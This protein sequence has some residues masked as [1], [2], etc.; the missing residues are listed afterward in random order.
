M[1]GLGGDVQQ[2]H[3]ARVRPVNA[4]NTPCEETGGKAGDERNPLSVVVNLRPLLSQLGNLTPRESLVR[5]GAGDLT[6]PGGAPHGLLQVPALLAGGAVHPHRA[7]L[8]R[9]GGA[10]L[11]VEELVRLAGGE[12]LAC[13]SPPEHA[14]VLLARSGDGGH[15]GELQAG[16]PQLVHHHVQGVDPHDGGGRH[17]PPGTVD[18]AGSP[19]LRQHG[20][21]V[22]MSLRCDLQSLIDNNCL[23]LQ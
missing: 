11:V 16:H 18:P 8:H 7:V 5:P 12:D 20:V 6:E 13:S 19:V 10:Q 15:A 2:V 21:K 17:L 4:H 22:N 14:P 9:E 3:P 1:P 23:D